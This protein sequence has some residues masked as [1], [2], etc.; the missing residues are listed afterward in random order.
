M[1]KILRFRERFCWVAVVVFLTVALILG[2]FGCGGGGGG[3]AGNLVRLHVRRNN[4]PVNL[5][6]AA[7]QEG[8]GAWQRLTPTTTGEYRFPVTDPQGRYGVAW[9]EDESGYV[10]IIQL[11]LQDVNELWIT[12]EP[13][14]I[15]T[16]TVS[17]QA[18]VPGPFAVAVN[19]Q[20][21]FPFIG[22]YALSQ[23]P[24]GTW[25]LLAAT[26]TQQDGVIQVTRVYVHRNLAVTSNVTHNI[27]FNNARPVTQSFSV[28]APGSEW[29]W[30]FFVTKNG[31][32]AP[33][34]IAQ[35]SAAASFQAP[36][37][38]S[39]LTQ[40]GDFYVVGGMSETQNV[41]AWKGFTTP[42]NTTLS[43]P[44]PLTGVGGNYPTV[45]G[46]S[47]DFQFWA[48]SLEYQDK[49]WSVLVSRRWLGNATS[50]TVPESALANVSGWQPA[51]SLPSTGV[52][53]RVNAVTTNHSN[54]LALLFS[55]QVRE[56]PIAEG[57]PVVSG[58]EIKV[59]STDIEGWRKRSKS[60]QSLRKPA[61]LK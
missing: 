46:L 11:T 55:P 13:E 5:I 43:L 29:S 8:T 50:Y 37:M 48:F 20:M 24:R 21:G 38:P 42:Q 1:R 31:T 4:Q 54:P 32:A 15:D 3:G 41:M 49:D 14:E 22:S 27:D 35:G 10:S 2:L 12:L 23:V 36:A 53:V 30:V 26:G 58:L 47:T 17:G 28:S 60:L 57:I 61:L 9:V 6:W 7:Y 44:N 34:A 59:A 19:G 56:V 52:N 16:Y 25:D 33:L 39:M 40:T 51:W 45:T 18:N